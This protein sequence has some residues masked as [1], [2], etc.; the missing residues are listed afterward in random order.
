MKRIFFRKPIIQRIKKSWYDEMVAGCKEYQEINCKKVNG[1]WNCSS[2][3]FNVK[4][5]CLLNILN[6][7]FGE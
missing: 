3:S 7:E 2:C 4:S 6:A 5:Y 1:G